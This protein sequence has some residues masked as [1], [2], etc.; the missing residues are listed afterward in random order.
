M[1]IVEYCK[2]GNLSNYLKSKRNIFCPT[3]VWFP[4]D[5]K[6]WFPQMPLGRFIL[7]NVSV[8]NVDVSFWPSL[9]RLS[10]TKGEKQLL[11]VVHLSHF[12]IWSGVYCAKKGLISILWLC[13]ET[14]V[15]NSAAAIYSKRKWILSKVSPHALASL[16]TNQFLVSLG[17]L[18]RLVSAKPK[19]V[20][21]PTDFSI[22]GNTTKR[23][24]F[25][26]HVQYT[27]IFRDLQVISL[28]CEKNY[29]KE[30]SLESC[31]HIPQPNA[32]FILQTWTQVC[33]LYPACALSAKPP[34]G[35]RVL[36]WDFRAWTQNSS[37]QNPCSAV[38]KAQQH[39]RVYFGRALQE[40]TLGRMSPSKG[41]W[42]NLCS[43]GRPCWTLHETQKLPP[44]K[45][46]CWRRMLSRAWPCRIYPGR[47][48][49]RLGAPAS[50]GR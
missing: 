11:G 26:A 18:H 49:L 47:S 46:H 19:E 32:C 48:L 34:K 37:P 7:P 36:K 16:L 45:G 8:G 22:N 4:D 33:Q 9:L 13:K 14:A 50:L 28:L 17:S 24:P 23:M 38:P 25:K 35:L 3:K 30:R 31:P 42:L 43:Q 2:Y 5:I 6:V 12:N 39:L 44:P 20:V 29:R 27:L 41:L 10:S 21:L 40:S 1:V 15:S